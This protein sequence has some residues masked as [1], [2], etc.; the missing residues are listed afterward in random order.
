MGYIKHRRPV[1]API[2]DEMQELGA[3]AARPFIELQLNDAGDELTLTNTAQ[4]LPWSEAAFDTMDG[5][6]TFDG[7][8]ELTIV[9]AGTYRVDFHMAYSA[10]SSTRIQAILEKD[11]LGVGSYA[12]QVPGTAYP[13]ALD[14][15]VTG[16]FSCTV[17]LL[18]T[19]KLRVTTRRLS[20]SAPTTTNGS[21]GGM[22]R[23]TKLD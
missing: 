2:D 17:A 20:G 21:N 1:L 18:A 4:A 19:D 13:H 7:V 15:N 11:P 14:S 16:G 6:V 22:L 10:T 3:G 8:D 12:T 9:E 23:L 5:A